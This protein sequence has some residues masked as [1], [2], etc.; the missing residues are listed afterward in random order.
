MGVPIGP[1]MVAGAAGQDDTAPRA[2]AG[3][4]EGMRHLWM[5]FEP[6]S[7]EAYCVRRRSQGEKIALVRAHAVYRRV[8]GRVPFMRPV[9][10]RT[11]QKLDSGS[12][13]E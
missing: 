8:A 13:P 1:S 10:R 11:K 9:D 3:R 12:G 4:M 7:P 5:R 2:L 6:C